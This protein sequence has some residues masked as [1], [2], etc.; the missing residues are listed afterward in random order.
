MPRNISIEGHDKG[1]PVARPGRRAMELYVD[2]AKLPQRDWNM[3]EMHHETDPLR[4]AQTPNT[5]K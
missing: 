2:V 3:Q 4:V 5:Y 1:K